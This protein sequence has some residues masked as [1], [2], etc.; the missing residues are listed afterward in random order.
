[1]WLGGEVVEVD[2]LGLEWA[3]CLLHNIDFTFERR[4]H[5]RFKPVQAL[6]VRSINI[7]SICANGRIFSQLKFSLQMSERID[8]FRIKMRRNRS[9]EKDALMMEAV[10]AY[11]A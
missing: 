3:L 5:W 1:M 2:D 11:M 7:R 8:R 9:E 10:P 4:I 6:F